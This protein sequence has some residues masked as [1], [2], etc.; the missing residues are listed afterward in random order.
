MKK[1]MILLF[2]VLFISSCSYHKKPSI[3]LKVNQTV[4][5]PVQYV[6]VKAGININSV[7]KKTPQFG[8]KMR[9]VSF[10]IR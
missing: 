10:S 7:S 6:T 3:T 1:H 8:D 9:Q 4:K 5:I 2:S